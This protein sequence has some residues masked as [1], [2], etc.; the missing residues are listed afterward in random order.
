MARKRNELPQLRRHKAKN[1]AY[2]QFRRRR[3]YVG[4]WGSRE[5][6]ATFRRMLAEVVLPALERAE[7]AIPAAPSVDATQLL[8]EDL[9]AEYLEHVARRYPERSRQPESIRL[10]LRALL[11]M[12][13]PTRVVDFT[14]RALVA[15]Q[16][17]MARTIGVRTV[18]SRI[19]MIVRMFRWGV[20]EELLPGSTWHGLQAVEALKP[21]QYGVRG[22]RKVRAATLQQVQA[23]MPHLP[24]RVLRT[25]VVVQWITGMRSGELLSMRKCDIDFDG[26]IWIYRPAQHKTENHEIDRQIGLIPE[27]QALLRPF[28]LRPDEAY[29]F[30][31]RDSDEEV[32][33]RK[34][35]GRKTKVQPSQALRH[36]KAMRE[37]KARIGERYT[38]RTYGQAVQ[39]ACSL[40]GLKKTG[41]RFSPHQ[42]RHAAATAMARQENILGAQKA[43][44]HSSSKTT[45]RYLHLDAEIAKP[46]FLVMKDDACSLMRALEA[47][48]EVPTEDHQVDGGL[49]DTACADES[50]ASRSTDRESETG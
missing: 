15:L 16:I 20:S 44:G 23:V 41:E 31:P 18:N 28:F 6:E 8:V 32:R 7:D 5:A 9:V 1:R 37:P 26:E 46:A 24:S 10:A 3:Y 21:G 30:D 33:T 13:G 45:E 11:A 17:E 4:P 14:P 34:R 22:P 35:A 19:T 40:A 12:Y 42:L 36:E 29:L 2:F 47:A 48:S 50:A 39:R 38:P 43:L 49:A 25:M 27:V